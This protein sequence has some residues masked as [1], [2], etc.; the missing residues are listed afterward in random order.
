MTNAN[1]PLVSVIVPAFEVAPYIAATLDSVLAQT[2]RRFEIVV[3]NDGSQDTPALEAALAPYRAHITYLTQVNSG[4]AAT[5]N[6]AIYASHG[7][8]LAFLD[9]DDLWEPSF[10]E[11]QLA[12]LAAAPGAVLAWADSQPFG[13]AGELPTLMALEPPSG[14]CDHEAL[15][16]GRCVVFTSTA[17]AHR[18][19]VLAVGAFDASLRRGEDFDLWLRLANRGQLVYN[20]RVLGR[21]RMNPAGLSASPVAMLQA[22][23][24]V[25]QRFVAASNL[26]EAVK[27]AAAAADRRVAAQVALHQGWASLSRGDTAAA[28][29]ELAKAAEELPGRG[30]R[31]M[32]G[33][34]AVAPPLAVAW[35]RWRAGPA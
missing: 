27:A 22:Q 9:A 4:A 34:L 10:L 14:Q 8:V 13:V 5:R 32:L 3:V 35:H 18:E 1:S 2:Y 15:L 20:R 25:R 23:I 28:R 26:P 21:R 7:D 33:L 29:R 16:T 24:A 30:L 11:E 6:R 12:F 17:I 19:D 31:A